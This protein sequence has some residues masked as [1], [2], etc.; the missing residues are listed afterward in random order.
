LG[1]WIVFYHAVNQSYI[2]EMQREHPE[3][4]ENLV[5]LAKQMERMDEKHHNQH[6]FGQE[7][8]DGSIQAEL[9]LID[10]VALFQEQKNNHHT[11]NVVE[12]RG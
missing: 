4:Y 9:A 6:S 10:L 12:R 5:W 11:A 7:D 1:D 8:L 2:Q 3:Y